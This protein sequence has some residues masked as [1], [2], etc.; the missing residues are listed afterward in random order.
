M[1]T[2]RTKKAWTAI[3]AVAAA[4]L[5][6]AGCS[7]GTSGSSNDGDKPAAE[8]VT[9]RFGHV[10]AETDPTAISVQEFADLVEEKTDGRVEIQ[11]FP[12]GQLGS[13]A[14]MD[15]ALMDGSLDM[16]IGGL[17]LERRPAL[18]VTSAPY[19]FESPEATVKSL[20]SEVADEMVWE[21]ARED[22][23]IVHIDSWYLGSFQ[24]TSNKPFTDPES[25]KGVTLRTTQGQSWIDLG[26]ALGATAV[27]I[28]FP[29]LYVALQTGTVDAQFN[30]LSVTTANKFAEVQ[31][32]YMPIDV[33]TMAISMVTSEKAWDK[34]SEED[35]Q[36]VREAARE[37]GDQHLEDTVAQEK[38]WAEDLEDKLE[39]VK[40]DVDAFRESVEENFLPK[41]D[42]IYGEGVYDALRKAGE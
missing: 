33:V 7:A 41:W 36:L 20:R 31:K 2:A 24:A 19:L 40:P 6:L 15:E 9:L 38:K 23:G 4:A 28:A 14:E 3:G 21:P 8:T 22:I 5:A 27:P 32:Y 37:A 34:I 39:L 13:E 1:N 42:P 18:A 30:P 25:A 10:Y 11:I 17:P 35:Q 12:G 29:E 16:R 26:N